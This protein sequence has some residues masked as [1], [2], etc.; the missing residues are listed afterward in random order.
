MKNLWNATVDVILLVMV[1]LGR[2]PRNLKERVGGTG[3]E[4]KIVSLPRRKQ[5]S[6]ISRDSP[7]IHELRKLLTLCLKKRLSTHY[8][9]VKHQH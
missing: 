3:I 7:K 2:L 4:T 5:L 9:N 1:A 6:L 8:V